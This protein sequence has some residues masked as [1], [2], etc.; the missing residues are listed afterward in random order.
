MEIGNKTTPSIDFVH[1][2]KK[3]TAQLNK[4]K[5]RTHSIRRQKPVINNK[6]TYIFFSFLVSAC[7]LHSFFF[8]CYCILI[9]ILYVIT[10][11]NKR[12]TT[13]DDT[14]TYNTDHF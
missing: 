5:E 13:I 3:N 12:Q 11:K 1:L 14:R 10:T 6:I 8:F 4:N 9:S 2:G 7:R